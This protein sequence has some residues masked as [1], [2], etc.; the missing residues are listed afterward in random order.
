MQLN[1]GS[2]LPSVAP[3]A[4]SWIYCDEALSWTLS[5]FESGLCL[6]RT[7]LS[8]SECLLHFAHLVMM[9]RRN[10]GQNALMITLRNVS[11]FL[12]LD[13]YVTE[14]E[15]SGRDSSGEGAV[16]RRLVD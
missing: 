5:I 4:I 13:T 12:L 7:L 8:S 9:G 10:S 11:L 3:P 16:E 6:S 2:A 15:N 14:A 1:S